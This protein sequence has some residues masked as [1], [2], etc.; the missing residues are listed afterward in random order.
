[1]FE[2]A[3]RSASWTAELFVNSSARTADSTPELFALMIANISGVGTLKFSTPPTIAIND[4]GSRQGSSTSTDT[5][6][7]NLQANASDELKQQAWK[8]ESVHNCPPQS[9]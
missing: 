4:A 2:S 1:M 3:A 8:S 6:P 7:N 5:L 9:M